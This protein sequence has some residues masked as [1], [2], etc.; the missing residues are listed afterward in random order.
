M[1]SRISLNTVMQFLESPDFLLAR[2]GARTAIRKHVTSYVDYHLRDGQSAPPVQLDIK[3]VNACNLRC[4]MCAQWGESGYNFTRP[5]S[6]VRD[7]VSLDTWKKLV[8]DVSSIKPWIY[9]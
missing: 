7:V 4:K 5:S 2:R 8:D 9:I 6:E 1:A 3:L